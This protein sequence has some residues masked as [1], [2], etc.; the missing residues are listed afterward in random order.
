[1]SQGNPNNP[2]PSQEGAPDSSERQAQEPIPLEPS[3]PEPPRRPQPGK[4]RIESPGLLDDFDEDADLESDPEVERIVK[5][6]PLKESPR[7]A[8]KPRVVEPMGD[9]ICPSAAWKAPAAIG[10]VV[11]VTAAVFA[12]IYAPNV[13]WAH[14]LIVLYWAAV[15]TATGLG[16]VVAS[17]LL[18]GRPVGPFESAGA[19][20]FMAVSVFLVVFSLEIPLTGGKLEEVLLGAAAYFGV[21][22]VA[23]RLSARDAAVVGGAHFGLALLVALG[24]LLAGVISSAGAGA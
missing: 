14:V 16:A 17:A 3:D 21:V 24:N 7:P 18:L 11:T 5:G 12:G 19:R 23:F 10:G 2:D 13:I 22:V 20:M 15:H 1:M 4:A 9:P 8:D 6:I